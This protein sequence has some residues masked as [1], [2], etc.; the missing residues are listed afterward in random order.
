M[1]TKYINFLLLLA[2]LLFFENSYSQ[3]SIRI[4]E[5][6]DK[7][8]QYEGRIG[9]NKPG[10]AEIYWPG[11]SCKIKF[12]GTGVNAILKEEEN[13]NYYDVIIDE[14]SIYVLRLDTLKKIYKL[15][16]NLKRGNHTVELFRRTGWVG[17]ITCFYGF[18]LFGR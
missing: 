15:A 13:N 8:I 4:V 14:D 5:P 7:H 1:K 2:T 17:G 10:V 16:S 18:Q 3:S 11:S 6:R 9:M 12:N